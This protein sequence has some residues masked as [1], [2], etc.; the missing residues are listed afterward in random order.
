MGAL[1]HTITAAASGPELGFLRHRLALIYAKKLSHSCLCKAPCEHFNEKMQPCAHCQPMV[2]WRAGERP[3][4]DI[5]AQ[6]GSPEMPRMT[7]AQQAPVQ[8][9]MP[10]QLAPRP[11]RAPAQ[12][13][14][15]PQRAPVAVRAE[16]VP[17]QEAPLPP[18]N[19]RVVLR[20]PGRQSQGPAPVP[21]ASRMGAAAE[22]QREP[23]APYTAEIASGA[24][25]PI[26]YEMVGLCLG[27]P[28]EPFPLKAV[29]L[30][31]CCGLIAAHTVLS[32]LGFVLRV[33]C[34]S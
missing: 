33:A 22:A 26:A 24:A 27:T 1:Q 31:Q 6:T 3:L 7:T 11:Q 29:T 32:V 13:A 21:E 15:P 2:Q 4:P 16:E 23:T 14:L 12:Q 28:L 10:P 9:V 19:P 8:P 20:P 25:G 34:P 17:V 30:I 5:P 18:E